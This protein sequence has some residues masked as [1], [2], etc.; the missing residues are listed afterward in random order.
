MHSKYVFLYKTFLQQCTLSLE[1][2]INLFIHSNSEYSIFDF[3]HLLM[4]SRLFLESIDVLF[5]LFRWQ[6][7]QDFPVLHL[8]GDGDTGAWQEN[9]RGANDFFIRLIFVASHFFHLFRFLGKRKRIYIIAYFFLISK[10]EIKWCNGIRIVYGTELEI[11]NMLLLKSQT[12]YLFSFDIYFFT[13]KTFLQGN[14]HVW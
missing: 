10:I 1:K 8:G 12:L 6:H 7:A 4:G 11:L 14:Q 9:W 5:L 2:S 13:F 3:I